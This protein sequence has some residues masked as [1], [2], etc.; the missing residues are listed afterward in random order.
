MSPSPMSCHR[1]VPLLLARLLLIGAITLTGTVSGAAFEVAGNE[2]AASGEAA[3]RAALVLIE[4][5]WSRINFALPDHPAQVNAIAALVAEAGRVAARY[6]GHAEPLIWQAL[7]L[8]SQAGINGGLGAI[9]LARQARALFEQAGRLDYRALDGAIPISLGSLYYKVPGFPL[10]FGDDD[11][12]RHYLGE[13][14]SISPDGMD[15]N[16][17][18]GDFLV[19]QGEYRKA[20]QVLTHALAAPAVSDR[21]VWDAGRRGEIRALLGKTQQKLAAD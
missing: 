1:P 19:Q 15:A 6:P 16:Y 20:A 18:Y 8:S 3:M 2:D 9:S 4:R 21:P 13:G 11:K 12:A 7:A 5:E 14:L 17:F 10:G